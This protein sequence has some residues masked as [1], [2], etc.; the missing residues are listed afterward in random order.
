MNSGGLQLLILVNTVEMR[1][2]T[3]ILPARRKEDEDER[4]EE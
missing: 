2:G 4:E 3:L 1:G